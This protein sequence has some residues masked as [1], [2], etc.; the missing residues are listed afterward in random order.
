MK[1]I[2]FNSLLIGL[3]LTVSLSSVQVIQAQEY[4]D[5][6]FNN[7]DRKSVKLDKQ[8]RELSKVQ[9][10]STYRATSASTEEFASK[11]VNPEYIARYKQPEEQ[12]GETQVNASGQD[13]YVENYNTPP[14]IEELAASSKYN[15]DYTSAPNFSSTFFRPSLAFNSFWGMGM[16]MGMGIGMG[17]GM[18]SMH[19]PWMNPWNMGFGGWGMGMG[20]MYNP[21]MNP[22]NMGFGGWGMPMGGFY[23]PWMYGGMYS[24]WA[25]NSWGNPWMMNR[26]NNPYRFGMM[27]WGAPVFVV[28]NPAMRE[29]LNY[30]P[31]SSRSITSPGVSPRTVDNSRIR[32]QTINSRGTPTT[33]ITSTPTSGRVSSEYAGSQNEMYNRSRQRASTQ[34]ISMNPSTSDQRFTRSSSPVSTMDMNRP[35]RSSDPSFTNRSS[36]TNSRYSSTPSSPSYNRSRSSSNSYGTNSYSAPSRGSSGNSWGGSSGSSFQ[37][38]SSPSF[39]PAG[40]SSG[41]RMSSGSSGA[42]RSGRQ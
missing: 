12:A 10:S 27:G 38:S 9:N 40:G 6:Y 22:W 26:W 19:N 30:E 13:Y 8:A 42:T 14:A 11:N 4:D 15:R 25:M 21:W 33:A 36:G 17:M 23:D 34:R 29:G 41:S 24:P 3:G 18:G 5:M 20:S 2:Q 31:R 35:R 37:R 28:N 39:S 7:K 32:E 1:K 16:G